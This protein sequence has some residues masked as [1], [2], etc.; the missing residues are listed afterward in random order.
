MST[1]H[2][3]TTSHTHTQLAHDDARRLTLGWPLAV[4][5]SCWFS[6]GAHTFDTHGKRHSPDWP[7]Y[8]DSQEMALNASFIGINGCANGFLHAPPKVFFGLGHRGID[9]DETNADTEKLVKIFSSA[10][11]TATAT[12]ENTIHESQ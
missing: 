7:T 12:M 5:T 4:S 11:A 2:G 3:P 8:F 1:A 6:R 10:M 9:R